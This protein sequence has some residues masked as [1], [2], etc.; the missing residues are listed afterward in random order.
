MRGKDNESKMTSKCG[1]ACGEIEC[2]NVWND[3]EC[4]DYVC[5]SVCNESDSEDLILEFGETKL[6]KPD[7]LECDNDEEEKVEFV[8]DI[9]EIFASGKP[10]FI[11]GYITKIKLT[12]TYNHQKN[13]K[14]YL[15][16]LIRALMGFINV[17]TSKIPYAENKSVQRFYRK[18]SD[19]KEL[20]L[21]FIIYE[22][23]QTKNYEKLEIE[24][25]TYVY[26]L[27][28]SHDYPYEYFDN[29]SRILIQELHLSN[30]ILSAKK[31]KKKM[32][33]KK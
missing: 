31:F 12:K 21:K 14:N 23:S 16:Y 1:N 3:E 8:S 24:T 19:W 32:Y 7:I 9:Y 30:K 25:I 6:E 22:R 33:N 17:K 11:D 18:L 5:V 20:I 15:P 13:I 26:D 28:M 29:I 27:L 10:E 4:D 2:S